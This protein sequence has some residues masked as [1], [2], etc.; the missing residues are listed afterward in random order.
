[1]PAEYK[2]LLLSA[3]LLIVMT[4]VQSMFGFR[5]HSLSALAGP[6]DGLVDK[7]VVLGRAKRANANMQTGLVIFGLM[8]LLAGQLNLFSAGTALG[9]ALFFWGRVAYAPLYWLGVPWLRTVAWA[10]SIVGIILIAKEL[11]MAAF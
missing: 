9:A 2:F 3:L 10:V 6:R 1:M 4:I 11:V 8:I 5:D 7:S